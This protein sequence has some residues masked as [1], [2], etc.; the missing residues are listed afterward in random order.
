[1]FFALI[2]SLFA[3]AMYIWGWHLYGCAI[4]AE[5]PWMYDV[6]A[7]VFAGYFDDFAY[8]HPS[9]LCGDASVYGSFVQKMAVAN[10][11]F[12]GI[13]LASV[14]GTVERNLETH[15]LNILWFV[16]LCPVFT[17]LLVWPPGAIALL[18]EVLP[19]ISRVRRAFRQLRAEDMHADPA[20]S[21][22]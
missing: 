17:L 8:D 13:L 21:G 4:K 6:F 14:L 20:L 12:C 10:L 2:S 9:P 3:S 22:S 18:L 5:R 16:L 19:F 1:M 7:G 11:Y 15:A